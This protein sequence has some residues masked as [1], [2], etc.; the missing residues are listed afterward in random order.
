MEEMDLK[1]MRPSKSAR[2]REE[3]E[4]EA[5]ANTR[6]DGRERRKLNRNG[7]FLWRHSDQ[8]RTQMEELADRAVPGVRLSYNETIARGLQ[9]LER[10]CDARDAREGV[11][12]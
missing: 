4:A 6:V 7:S 1:Q 9:A 12:E 11:K 5:I 8:E 2:S 3:A 10:E